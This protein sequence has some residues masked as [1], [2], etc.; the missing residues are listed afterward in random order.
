MCKQVAVIVTVDFHHSWFKKVGCLRWCVI[1]PPLMHLKDWSIIII[2]RVTFHFSIYFSSLWTN[3]MEWFLTSH[4]RHH[5]PP[6]FALPLW[7]HSSYSFHALALL[8]FSRVPYSCG[9]HRYWWPT[10]KNCSGS[11]GKIVANSLSLSA[12]SCFHYL[13][14]HGEG[15]ATAALLHSTLTTLSVTHAAR[16]L[17]TVRHLHL[18]WRVCSTWPSRD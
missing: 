14:S 2:I 18:G 3:M 8:K 1:V 7:T 15:P 5:L 6:S 10:W 11:G 16:P 17:S 12:V 13:N 9:S 4:H